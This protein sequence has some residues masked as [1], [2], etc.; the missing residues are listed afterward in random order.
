MLCQYH[1]NLMQK[2]LTTHED[3][4]FTYDGNQ[5]SPFTRFSY[6]KNLYRTIIRSLS[7]NLFNPELMYTDSV[8]EPKSD[9]E[10]VF[11]TRPINKVESLDN[12]LEANNKRN[13]EI[14]SHDDIQ[15]AINSD[16]KGE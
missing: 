10:Q 4:K 8:E 14:I 7:K 3:C 15:V 16:E 12:N 6:F 2:G 13:N 11:T 5:A 9:P 1:F